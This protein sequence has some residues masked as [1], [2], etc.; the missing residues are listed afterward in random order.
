[1]LKLWTRTEFTAAWRPV[2]PKFLRRPLLLALI[3]LVV[4][5]GIA[6][7]RWTWEE[8]T[9]LRFQRDIINGFHW[10]TETLR[11]ARRLSPDE[12]SEGQNIHNRIRRNHPPLNQSA[13]ER[14]KKS[15]DRQNH[16][17]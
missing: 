8:T 15:F 11:E 2:S 4:F 6:A 9:H 16:G 1:M 3:A 12:N 5:G 10:G 14:E 13:S 17:E 7:R